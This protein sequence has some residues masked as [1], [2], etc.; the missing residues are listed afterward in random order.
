MVVV[1]KIYRYFLLIA[2]KFVIAIGLM[3]RSVFQVVYLQLTGDVERE[4]IVATFGK[5]RTFGRGGH[6]VFLD[7][8][9]LP[10]PAYPV[11]YGREIHK[12]TLLIPAPA[13]QA[14]Q[15]QHN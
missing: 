10:L 15:R 1:G 3:H 9:H 7:F 8:V 12:R 5:A 2:R 13:Q 11:L 6:A 4:I 14:Q